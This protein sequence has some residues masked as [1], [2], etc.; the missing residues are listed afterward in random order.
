MSS[1]TAPNV[2]SATWYYDIVGNV[3][4]E[5]RTI[6]GVTKNIYY[7]YN[8]DNSLASITGGT[9]STNFAATVGGGLDF[10]LSRHIAI[11]PVQI[12]YYVTTLPNRVNDHQNNLRLAAGI[13]IR[14]GGSD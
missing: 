13:V 12:E 14:F 3:I 1:G 11:R 7:T 10:N 4:Q 9:S 5:Q 8:G 6:A 2:V